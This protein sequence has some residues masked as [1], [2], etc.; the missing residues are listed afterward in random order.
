[1]RRSVKGESSRQTQ[2]R[3]SHIALRSLSDDVSFLIAIFRAGRD[4]GV[5]SSSHAVAL[6]KSTVGD[7]T[8][9]EDITFELLAP[10]TWFFTSFAYFTTGAAGCGI[11]KQLSAPSSLQLNRVDTA[12]IWDDKDNEDE[13]SNGDYDSN[14]DNYEHYLSND[15]NNPSISRRRIPWSEDDDNR[16]RKFKKEGKPWRWICDQFPGRSPGAVQVRWH[17]KLRKNS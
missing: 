7:P 4:P 15:V 10:G 16:L 14:S 12:P 3:L 11:G 6:L 17:A 8:T 13:S 9:L 5:L 1:M 2:W